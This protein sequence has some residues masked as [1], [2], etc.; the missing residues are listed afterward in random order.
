MATYSNLT[1]LWA[2]DTKRGQVLS[3]K[4][5]DATRQ[6]ITAALD[7]APDGAQLVVFTNEKRDKVID[8]TLAQHPDV[9]AALFQKVLHRLG[10]SRVM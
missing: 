4:L 5:T 1:G 2:K 10:M 9:E 3:A 8:E 7:G 6:K